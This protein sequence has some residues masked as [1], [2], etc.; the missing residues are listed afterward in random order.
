MGMK[1][2]QSINALKQ[3]LLLWK[4]ENLSIGFV[5]TMGHLH[6]GHIE[7][8]NQARKYCDKVVVSIFVNPL[9]FN[10]ASDFDAYPKTREADQQKLRAASADLLFLPTSEMMYPAGQENTTKV[11]VPDITL[12]LEGEHRPGHF[13]GVSTVVSKLFNLVQPQLA[14]FGEKD[15]QQLLLIK[16]MVL[17]LNMPVEV[18]SVA[19]YRHGDGLAMS[20]RNSRL[21]SA[22]RELA[23]ELHRVLQRVS[24][25]FIEARLSLH[26]IESVAIETLKKKGF[27][28][29]YVSIRDARNLSR[30][31]DS[32]VNC[33]VLAAAWLG[34][35]RLID[36]IAIK[37]E[38]SL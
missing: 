38:D 19:T 32:S 11:S 16:K 25:Q 23:P 10:D 24:E 17:D 27:N 3:T 31:V 5:P 36:N 28:V 21:S 6:A 34:D 22:N 8:V 13:D 2:S 37:P 29:E 15:Y 33:R 7:L 26:E 18:R 12:E 4:K 1:I 9:Q 14:F 35:V 30:P 20:S